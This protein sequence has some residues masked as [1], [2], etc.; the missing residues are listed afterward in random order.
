MLVVLK[1]TCKVAYI[2]WD[3][4]IIC[5]DALKKEAFVVSFLGGGSLTNEV[6]HECPH[7]FGVGTQIS[8]INFTELWGAGKCRKFT[9]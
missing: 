3:V 6:N 8:I 7:T 1:A 9:T 4:D 5:E 2:A